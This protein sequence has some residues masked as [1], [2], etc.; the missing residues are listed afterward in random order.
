[1]AHTE[2]RPAELSGPQTQE[3]ESEE[4]VSDDYLEIRV[5]LNNGNVVVI[6]Q[7][8]DDEAEEVAEQLIEQITATDRP[9]W[10]LIDSTLCFTGE[11][12]AIEV[13]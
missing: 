1:M 9:R 11:V 5:H 4:E 7:E 3:A 6:P 13:L 8:T 10:M 2:D 12:S